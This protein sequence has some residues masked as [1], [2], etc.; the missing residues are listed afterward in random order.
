MAVQ[1]L[2]IKKYDEA[3]LQSMVE[4]ITVRIEKIR[5]AQRTPINLPPPEDPESPQNGGLTKE[6]IRNLESF[7][8]TQ[9]SGGGFYEISATD[10]S[11]PTVITMT[12]QPY[13][14]PQIY[15]ERKPPSPEEA[16][17]GIAPI[18]Q[19]PINPRGNNVAAFPNGFPTFQQ[20]IPAQLSGPA[21]GTPYP[22]MPAAP[23]IG[24]N[25]WQ[26]YSA[27]I[28][29]RRHEDETRALREENARREREAQ[30]TKHAA[31][32][33][34]ERMAN[35]QRAR[36]LEAQVSELKNLIAGLANNGA[37][38]PEIELLKQQAADARAQADR[39]RAERE[40]ERRNSEMLAMIKA[41][42]EAT[43]RQIDESNRRTEMLMQQLRELTANKGPDPMIM[44]FTE[45]TRTNAE[46]IKEI[47]RNSKEQITQLQ[48]QMLKPQDIL[49]ITT[50]AHS[51]ADAN[52]AKI[53]SAY[54]GVLDMQTKVMEQALQMAPQGSGVV[55]V[56][57]DGV[58]GLKDF[59]ERYVG[60][61][62]AEN[63]M[64]SQAQVQVAQAQAHVATV[65]AAAAV[66]AP[67]PG[68][69]YAPPAPREQS[70]LAGPDVQVPKFD[71]SIPPSNPNDSKIK[72]RGRTDREWFGPALEEVHGMREQVAM[73]ID[74]LRSDPPKHN[75]DG[76]NLG[77][78]PEQAAMGIIMATQMAVQQ[79]ANIPALIDLLMEK[80]YADFIEVLLPDAPDNYRIDVAQILIAKIARLSGEPTPAEAAAEA[81]A[82]EDEGEKEEDETGDDS[83]HEAAPVKN[84]A[85]IARIVK[86]AQKPNQTRRA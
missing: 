65:Q 84:G 44:L 60:A 43:Q 38:N 37:K 76:S 34:A 78:S 16:A 45:M 36:A 28:E 82:D 57:R 5:G 25:Q 4:P 14:D 20:Q 81:T 12:W 41:T 9:W 70:Q 52:G 74:S 55:D 69:V 42:Q 68:V 80:R 10:S 17:Q 2:Q 67:I 86:P 56:V 33:A 24:T 66:G 62:S 53:A 13:Y 63:R 40:A 35:E 1:K 27:E 75:P 18:V 79:G 22:P 32:L 49:A 47:S 51:A 30:E 31:Q 6:D 7:L 11:Q 26:A 59:A 15:P 8:A 23:P 73:F 85:P 71:A 72:R 83:E 46:A 50:G 19:L 39:E 61:K 58:N 3:K 64:A 21:Y 29:K 54:S 48:M 77:M